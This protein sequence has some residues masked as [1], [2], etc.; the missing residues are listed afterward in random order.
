MRVT[1]AICTWNRCHSLRRTLERMV[2][3]RVPEDLEWE[4]LVV[5]NRSTDETDETVDSFQGRLPVRRSWEPEPGLSNARN[6]ALAEATGD[7]LIWTD[8][9]VLVDD[10]WLAAYV[11]A[12]RRWPDADLF[13]GPIEPLFEGEPPAW[14][15]RV[16][17]WIGPVFGQQT[18]GEEPV[19]LTPEILPLGPYGGNMAMRR[20]ALR[21]FPFDPSLGVRHGEYATGEETQVMARMLEAGLEGWWTPEPRVG[22]WIPRSSQTPRYVRRWFVGCGKGEVHLGDQSALRLA[23]RPYRLLKKALR[24]EMRYRLRRYRT[25][26]EEWVMDLM[27]AG[28]MHG[29]ILGLAQMRTGRR[30][31]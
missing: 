8:D 18:L 22:H 16:M 26:P 28:K 10:D 23:K 31:P 14:I 25:P 11:R 13:G 30:W 29:I 5:N 3:M 9:D 19:R 1:V 12:F 21:R 4:L 7:Y 17:H 15:L 20:S 2:R 27:H 24:F 6:R